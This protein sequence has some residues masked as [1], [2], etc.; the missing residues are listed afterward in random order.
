M[1]RDHGHCTGTW[2]VKNTCEYQDKPRTCTWTTHL[3]WFC[4]KE[5]KRILSFHNKWEPLVK[6]NYKPLKQRLE[7]GYFNN[8]RS[9]DP[10]ARD[11]LDSSSKHPTGLEWPC[12]GK[13][14]PKRTYIH[15]SRDLLQMF[16]TT[17]HE[18]DD[19]P[20]WTEHQVTFSQDQWFSLAIQSFSCNSTIQTRGYFFQ[21]TGKT[22]ATSTSRRDDP[23]G[24][25]V[26]SHGSTQNTSIAIQFL[27]L[28]R[29]EDDTVWHSPTDMANATWQGLH[30]WKWRTNNTNQEPLGTPTYTPLLICTV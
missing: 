1:P 3:L 11:D 13:L 17:I 23:P 27:N 14:Q 10:T 7:I 16:E 5:Y 29:P 9:Q 21:E 12:M 8:R 6:D 19:T 30:P 4:N 2:H 25:C 18:W 20:D 26:P 28:Y 15:G 24:P 22:R